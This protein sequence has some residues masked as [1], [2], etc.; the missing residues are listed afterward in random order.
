MRG[1]VLP[2]V[3]PPSSIVR[4]HFFHYRPNIAIFIGHIREPNLRI[5]SDSLPRFDLISIFPSAILHFVVQTLFSG[6]SRTTGYKKR[7]RIALGDTPEG[8]AT[9][10]GVCF[11]IEE[12]SSLFSLSFREFRV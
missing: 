11:R 12:A 7:V 1:A 4:L 6:R 8:Q 3:K 2:S 9:V 5:S 10:W